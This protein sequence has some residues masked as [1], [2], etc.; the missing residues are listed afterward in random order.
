MAETRIK[1]LYKVIIYLGQF[2]FDTLFIFTRRVKRQYKREMDAENE[3]GGGVR[4]GETIETVENHVPIYQGIHEDELDSR[5]GHRSF[6]IKKISNITGKA[7]ERLRRIT[8]MGWRDL[9]YEET[10]SRLYDP[11]QGR[12]L[13]AGITKMRF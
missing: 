13:A 9:F 4:G 3:T 11:Q 7:E 8:A 5:E 12:S 10:S 2:K 1:Y 6:A